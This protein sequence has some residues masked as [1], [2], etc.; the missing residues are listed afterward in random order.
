[1]G[2]QLVRKFVKQTKVV[3]RTP[4]EAGV[5]EFLSAQ[6]KANVRAC[7]ARVLGEPDAAVWQE[8]RRLDP[9]NRVL[10]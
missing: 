10:N 2:G 4:D 6:T 3:S 1:M 9:A 7:R 5:N 8:L